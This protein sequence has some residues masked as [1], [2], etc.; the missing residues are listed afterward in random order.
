MPMKAV[1]WVGSSLDDLR[2]LP[3]EVKEEFGFAIY[4]AQCGGKHIHAKPL[5]GLG[6][7]IL[8]VVEN[9]DGDTF[10]AVYTV[11]FEE[12]VYVLHVFQKKSQ[13][14]IA[15]PRHEIELIQRRFEIARR[16]H[17]EWTRKN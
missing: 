8:E 9:F 2:E 6:G 16:S 1:R 3:D 15:T 13:K 14:G 5:K 11:Q 17:E 7:G 12:A 4:Q 10:R